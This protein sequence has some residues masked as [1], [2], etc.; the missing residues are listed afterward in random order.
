MRGPMIGPLNGGDPGALYGEDLVG[1]IVHSP[2]GAQAGW[3]F[4]APAGTTITAV[5]YYR[6]L[7]TEN[8]GD[9]IA[10]LLSA[11]GTPLDTCRT[12]PDPCSHPNNQVAI[13]L[14]GLNTSRLFF[15]IE[16][17]PVA[18]DPDCLAGGSEARCAG[19]YVLREGDAGGDRDAVG[20]ELGRGVVGWWCRV[21]LGAVDVQRV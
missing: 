6:N 4:T 8:N 14:T 18:P 17:E 20:L 3:S 12:N 15:G 10:G 13:T 2:T 9:W 7:E 19:R 21:G 16:C 11:N 5:S 1:S